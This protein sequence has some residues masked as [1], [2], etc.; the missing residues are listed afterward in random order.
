MGVAQLVRNRMVFGQSVSC[1][2]MIRFDD[3]PRDLV[4]TVI[5]TVW[6][7]DAHFELILLVC[8][9]FYLH[10]YTSLNIWIF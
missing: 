5:T 8:I 6:L 3:L 9:S 2:L 1:L 7:L 4:P 10:I